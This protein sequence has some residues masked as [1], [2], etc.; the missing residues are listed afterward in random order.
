MNRSS[1]LRPQSRNNKDP[2]YTVPTGKYVSKEG[3]ETNMSR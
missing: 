1:F 2:W 3:S